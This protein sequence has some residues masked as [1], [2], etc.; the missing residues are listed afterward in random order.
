MPDRR[1]S[2]R[3]LHLNIAFKTAV[4]YGVLGSLWILLSDQL[5]NL[6]ARTPEI[7]ARWQTYKGWGYVAA[8]SLLLY[9]VLQVY[10]ARQQRAERALRR[11]EAELSAIVENA[12]FIMMIVDPDRRVQKINHHGAEFVGLTPEEMLGL[13]GGEALRC[14]HALDHPSGCGYGPV[15]GDCPVRAAVLDTLETGESRRAVEARMTFRAE[16]GTTT[17]S[18]L[19]FTTPLHL[20]GEPRVLVVLQDITERKDAEDALRQSEVKFRTLFDSAGDAIFI[21]DTTG[22]LLEVNHEA[23]HRL[24]YPREA[25]LDM[26]LSQ[27]TTADHAL[28]IPERIGASGSQAGHEAVIIETD[29]VSREGTTIPTEMSSRLISYEGGPAV[30]SVARDITERQRME[31]QLRQ[32]QRLAAV[33]QLAAGVAHDFRNLLTT[34]LLYAQMDRRHPGL[35]PKVG[36]DLDIIMEESNRAADLVQ[37]MLDFS[38]RAMIRRE[39][40]DLAAFV[41]G[42]LDDLLRRTIP[43]HVKLALET[44]PAGGDASLIVRADRGRIQ[45]ALM[46][47]ALNARDAM[48]DGG[49]LRFALS[50]VEVKRDD[51][52]PVPGM[53]PGGYV[54]LTVSDTGTGMTD[55]VQDHLFEPFF[56]TKDVDEGTGLGLAQVYGIVR[57]HHGHVDVTSTVGDGTTFRIYLPQ[58]EDEDAVEDADD[59]EPAPTPRGRGETILVVED[60][61]PILRAVEAGLTSLNY[62]VVSAPDGQQAMAVMADEDVDLVL[63]D[64]VMPDMG[65]KVL[66]HELRAASPNLPVL[67]MTGHVLEEDGDALKEAGFSDVIPKPFSMPCLATLIRAALDAHD[68]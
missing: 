63:T 17:R 55:E 43:E 59:G 24:G 64:V 3:K 53:E 18:L 68:G 46:N 52:P 22:R 31:E 27:I 12:P 26:S 67:A 4:G 58:A 57:Q 65:G 2:P 32:Q 30:L 25:L 8:T 5:V 56:T 51:R 66:L 10:V 6:L 33:G 44:S 15:C 13:R 11:S 47:L 41:D 35:P 38:S 42:L 1:E 28:P 19:V 21:H 7:A 29:Q 37:Q 16:G 9:A 60:A 36:K 14:I 20:A 61:G 48:P 40:L 54:C 34:I 49:E 39:P 50:P 23:V 62:R 45:Q